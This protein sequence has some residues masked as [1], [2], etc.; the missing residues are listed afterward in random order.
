MKK[1]CFILLIIILSAI[2]LAS[3]ES[4]KAS[5]S[6]DF[7]TI[8]Q[9]M[10]LEVTIPV[11]ED[12]EQDVKKFE[13]KIWETLL[14]NCIVK[15][16]QQEELES[17]IQEIE[18]Q[19]SYV[20]YF[21]NKNVSDLI[22]EIHGMTV[23][24]LA[25]EQLKKKYAIELIAENEDLLLSDKEYNKELAKRARENEVEDVQE[26]ENMFGREQLYSTFLEER[27]LEFLKDN[28]K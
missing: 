20:T 7:I 15:E 22:E 6:N 25:K 3:C 4:E 13:S 23:E 11:D 1:M 2:A 5:I 8:N 18:T 21:G 19:Y 26:Y 17:L 16:F 14:D 12:N 28:L 24:E 27:V 9:Y 10:D